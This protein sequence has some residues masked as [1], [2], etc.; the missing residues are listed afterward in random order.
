MFAGVGE[1]MD[2][3]L[4]DLFISGVL[5]TK[6]QKLLDNNIKTVLTV[7]QCPLP[8]DKN[9][10]IKYH[11]VRIDDFQSEDISQFF[12]DF[13]KVISNGL[14]KGRVLVHCQA[15]MSRSTTA[16]IS[17]MV[18]TFNLP[19]MEC[20]RSIRKNHSFAFP[21]AGFEEQLQEFE[22]KV[23]VSWTPNSAYT[24]HCNKVIDSVNGGSKQFSF[25][26]DLIKDRT[27][28]NGPEAN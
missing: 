12:E 16:I 23:M 24:Y 7:M 27:D 2:E 19:Y 5:A 6:R 21:N 28:Y 15:G 8:V 11:F 13:I 17:Y 1:K 4:P 9:A 14:Q 20:L 26:Y 25:F 18:A 22:K 10:D 3:V